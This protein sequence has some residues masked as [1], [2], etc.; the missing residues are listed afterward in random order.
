MKFLDINTFF[1]PRAGGIRSYHTAK[2]EYF[3]GHPEDEYTLVYPGTRRR[4]LDAA[5]NVKLVEVYGL[6][7]TRD[8]EGYRLLLDYPSVHRL[9]R[10]VRPDIVEAGDPWLTGLYCRY[11]LRR[12]PGPVRTSFYHAD[13]IDTYVE[14]FSPGAPR[15]LR[16]AVTG[17]ASHLFYGMQRGYDAT[18]VPSRVMERKLRSK[19]VSRVV[20]FPFGVDPIFLASGHTREPPGAAAPENAIRFLYAGRLDREKGTALLLKVIPRLLEA[21]AITVSV[22]GR[23]AAESA[24]RALTHPRY[25]FL[26]FLDSRQRM[27][28]EYRRHHVLLA[29]GPHETFGLGPLEAMASGM[30]VVGP[31]SGG[32]GELLGGM[33]SPFVFRTGDADSFYETAL[34]AAASDFVKESRKAREYARRFGT[35]EQAI[36]RMV[37]HYKAGSYA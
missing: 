15:W 2:I 4:F 17:L 5:A 26:G 6:P 13:P 14:P 12:R 9:I 20:C 1:G 3:A 8:G 21:Q 22:A 36:A 16:K 27:A 25:R 24:F 28:E 37:E 7:L 23:G 19:G 32:T 11:F 34:A 18:L 29:P 31:D 35:W 33:S 30:P 10:A